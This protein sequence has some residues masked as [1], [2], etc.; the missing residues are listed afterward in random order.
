MRNRIF[1]LSLAIAFLALLFGL[2]THYNFGAPKE[3]TTLTL[4]N[5]TV[6]PQPR[7]LSTFTLTDMNGKPFTQANLKGHWSLIFF[8]FTHCPMLCPT[9]L[10]TLN[11]VYQKLQ[12]DQQQPMPQIV[13]ISV[14]PERDSP[15]RIK[16][17]VTGFNPHFFGATGSQQQLEELTQKFSVM[18][19]K[20]AQGDSQQDYTIDHSG[21]LLLTD[22][23]GNLLA[24]FSTPHETAALT[25]NLEKIINMKKAESLN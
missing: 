11:E 12:A 9:T 22:P 14:D 7:A 17:Y 24:I 15:K 4:T 16:Q 18:Y 20:V 13:F 8:G 2:W 3:A 1:M 23:N 5:G 21:T 6:F 10:A 19:A 25:Q